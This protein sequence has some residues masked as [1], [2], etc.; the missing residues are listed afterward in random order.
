MRMSDEEVERT[1]IRLRW[2]DNNA[3]PYCPMRLRNRLR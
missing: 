2:Q 1:F 3:A